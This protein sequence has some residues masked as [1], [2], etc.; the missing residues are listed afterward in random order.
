MT[1]SDKRD[2]RSNTEE[3][4]NEQ[5]GA[6]IPAEWWCHSGQSCLWLDRWKNHIRWS[7]S[8]GYI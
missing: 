3:N 6:L 5:T 2:K 7:C 8:P 1:F 4:R